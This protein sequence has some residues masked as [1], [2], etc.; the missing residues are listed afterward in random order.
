MGQLLTHARTDDPFRPD[1]S[2]MSE[3]TSFLVHHIIQTDSEKH[4][5]LIET[6]VWNELF[7][8]SWQIF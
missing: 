1:H 3:N 4:N 6:S 7:P 5:N 2:P 8:S